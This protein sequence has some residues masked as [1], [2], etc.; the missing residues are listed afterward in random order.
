MDYIKEFVLDMFGFKENLS[1]IYLACFALIGTLIYL[2]RR[3]KGG[4]IAFLLPR[5]IWT[6][7][8]VRADVG[9]YVLNRILSVFGVFARFAAVPA[10][11]AWVASSCRVRHLIAL[12]YHRSHLH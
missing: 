11:A 8:S 9:L 2:I 6:H 4:I 7:K 3:E 1:P 5:A 10:V 12:P